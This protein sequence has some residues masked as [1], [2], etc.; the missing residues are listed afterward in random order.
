[1]GS[2]NQNT[3]SYCSLHL[4]NVQWKNPAEHLNRPVTTGAMNGA[5]EQHV[6]TCAVHVGKTKKKKKIKKKKA[7]VKTSASSSKQVMGGMEQ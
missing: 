3:N 5:S 4:A 7:Q 6:T 1:M 2:T